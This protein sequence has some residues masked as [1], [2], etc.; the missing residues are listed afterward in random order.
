MKVDD[1]L[2][3][4]RLIMGLMMGV[5]SGYLSISLSWFLIV[6]L[7]IL[8]YVATIPLSIRLIVGDTKTQK[9]NAIL[10]GVGTY[11]IFWITGWILFYNLIY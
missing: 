5:V 8:L 11:A 3:L 10:N 9:R 1:L 2:Y 4:V 7:G 6:L